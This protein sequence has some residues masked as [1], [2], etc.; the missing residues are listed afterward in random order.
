MESST[1]IHEIDY[2]TRNTLGCVLTLLLLAGKVSLFYLYS[3]SQND[4]VRSINI[5]II[6]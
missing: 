1:G 6:R 2:A 3:D 5:K 4:F